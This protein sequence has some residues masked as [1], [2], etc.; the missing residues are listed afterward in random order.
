MIPAKDLVMLPP[1]MNF[2]GKMS[3]KVASYLSGWSN[4]I[5]QFSID[6][7]WANITGVA[8]YKGMTE[9]ELARFFQAEILKNT[10]LP[11][12][13]GVSNTRLRAKI[14]SEINK[15]L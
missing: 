7:Y 5:E 14:L 12:S 10:G 15:P 11:V 1:D 8:H 2:Y 4:S 9:S 3:E 6:E 13:I